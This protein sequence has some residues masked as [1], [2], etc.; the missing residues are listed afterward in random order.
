[1]QKCGLTS[2]KFV[3]DYLLSMIQQ[4]HLKTMRTEIKSRKQ[5][6]SHN[7][8]KCNKYEKYFINYRAN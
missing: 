7:L 1:M 4:W 8:I 5:R 6:G 2:Q 3:P